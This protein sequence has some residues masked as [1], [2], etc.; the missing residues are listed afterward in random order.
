MVVDDEILGKPI[1][2]DDA[3][4]MMKKLSGRSHQVMSGVALVD[5]TEVPKPFEPKPCHFSAGR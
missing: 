5:G 2:R 3:L 1:N 4:A